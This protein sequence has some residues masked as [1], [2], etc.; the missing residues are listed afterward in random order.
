MNSPTESLRSQKHDHRQQLSSCWVCRGTE[1]RRPQSAARTGTWPAG[2]S[3]SATSRRGSSLKR[4]NRRPLHEPAISH[5]RAALHKAETDPAEGV[6]SSECW[7]VKTVRLCNPS[8][9][10]QQ[11]SQPWVRSTPPKECLLIV[12][13]NCLFLKVAFTR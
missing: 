10:T 5:V 8:V 11:V 13:F 3:S 7:K 2:I 4:H 9:E 12:T 6:C 1:Q